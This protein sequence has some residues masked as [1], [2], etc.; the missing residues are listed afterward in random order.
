MEENQAN[1]KQEQDQ[2]NHLLAAVESWMHNFTTMV[3]TMVL[4]YT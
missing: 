4:T 2:E 3:Q 1:G